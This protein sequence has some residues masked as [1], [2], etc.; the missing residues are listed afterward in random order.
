[1]GAIYKVRHR[2]LDEVRVVKVM[3]PQVAV[4]EELKQRFLEEAKTA[5]RLKHP[6]IGTIYDFALDE[7]GTAYL[8][9]EFIEGVNLTELLALKGRPPIGLALEIAHQTLLALGYLHRGNVVHRD[10]A[11]DNLMLTQD[12]DGRALVK[13][14][15]LGIAKA[16][17]KPGG[18][19]ST[20]VFLGKLKYASPE[21]YGSLPSGQTLDGRSDIY[22][23]GLVLYELVTGTR[24]FRGD[25][26]TE[27]LRAHVFESPLA[28][29]ESDPE[30]RV[31]SDL[32]AVILKALEK[33]RDDRFASAEECDREILKIGRRFPPPEKLERTVATRADTALRGSQV[34]TATPS[35]QSRLDRRF[36]ARSST[37]YRES[38]MTATSSTSSDQTVA[39]APFRRSGRRRAWIGAS[40][41]L[42][43]LAAGLAL[44]RPWDLERVRQPVAP[45]VETPAPAIPAAEGTGPA[46]QRDGAAAG[47]DRRAE[48]GGHLGRARGSRRGRVGS[49]CPGKPRRRAFAPVARDS[50]RAGRCPGTVGRT[51][52]LRPR[53]GEGRSAAGRTAKLR[54]RA[55]RL[56]GRG[57]GIR[58]GRNLEPKGVGEEP[59][60]GRTHR[61]SVRSRPFARSRPCPRVSVPSAPP[62]P[63]RLPPR[64]RRR[65]RAPPLPTRRRS[66]RSFRSTKKPRTRWT[67]TSMHGSIPHSPEKHVAASKTPGRDS[68]PSR[69][70]WRSGRS[71]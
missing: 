29:S 15:D 52:R 63:T 18:L 28:F 23:L 43:V 40:G 38:G 36:A 16:V 57:R 8:V 27:L 60:S 24:P 65:P 54:G 48:P 42:L 44:L 34:I 56:R 61:R 11:P 69:S 3:R 58:P 22:C 67:S 10:I 59:R 14:I 45:P 13:V 46:G 20:G 32:R 41:G 64:R 2:L 51:L 68:S 7:D 5:T 71:S 21:Q 31:P 17:D 37:P 39:A 35:A 33:N 66:A 55:R 50:G 47:T 49:S 62:E 1:M 70:S 30:G 9:M 25:T 12:E 53:T 4:D 26:A 6:N 19:T